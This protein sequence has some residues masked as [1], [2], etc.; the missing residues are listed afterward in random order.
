MEIFNLLDKKAIEKC[1]PE[2]DQFC[3]PIF[4]IKKPNG[5]FRFILNLKRLNTFID[6]EHFKLEDYRTVCK[7]LN[8]N[9]YLASLDL[10][11]AYYMI[12]IHKK[13]RRY[14][15]F[16]FLGNYYQFNVLPFGLCTAPL[17]FTKI[18]KPVMAHLREMGLVSVVYLDDFLCISK[19]FTDCQNNIQVTIKTLT[20]LGFIINQ[21]K[22]D[23][24]PTQNCKFLGL[25]FNSVNMTIGITKEKRMNCL[26]LIT[27]LLNKKSMTIKFLAQVIGTLISVCPAIKYG[28][29]YTKTLERIKYLGLNKNNNNYDEKT[30]LNNESKQDLLWWTR[31]I[32][33]SVNPIRKNNFHTVIYTDAS[34]TGWGASCGPETA[35]GRWKVE[36]SK[37]HINSLELMAAFFG[38]KCFSKELS[39][40][41]IL[42]RIDN[43]TAV[44]YINRQGGVQYPHLHNITKSI[45]QWCECRNLWIFASYINTKDN[46][47]ADF[48][49]R[50]ELENTEWQLGS[51]YF[52]QILQKFGY[53]SIDLFAS[54]TNAK[55]SQYV[56][57]HPDP[58]AIAVDAFTLNWRN[59][60]FYAFPP[61][62][63]LLKVL[64]KI[65]TDQA[66]GIVIAPYWPTQPWFPIYNKLLIENP[67]IFQPSQDLLMLNNSRVLHPLHQKLSLMAG[68]LSG[69]HF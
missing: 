50:R 11:D 39:N 35:S 61:F 33:K 2:M 24:T 48:E 25:I 69:N 44:S 55:C 66:T 27:D 62:C 14:L 8:Q 1:E 3:S 12:N 29:L 7:L 57:W 22:C 47:I 15:R 23:F 26:K 6:T 59:H 32:L 65:V 42:L 56:S 28:I 60:Y 10:K 19:S 63:M 5:S 34:S 9:D 4:L 53:P 51:C 52:R 40:C 37:L 31:N 45:W 17:I 54:R 16:C 20:K 43:I 13:S 21:N 49:S 46:I 30:T 36:E 67:I 38:L 64:E 18:M 58:N 41:E 68:L